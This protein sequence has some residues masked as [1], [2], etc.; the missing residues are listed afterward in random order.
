MTTTTTRKTTTT[1]TSTTRKIS[2]DSV[3]D[4]N[5]TTPNIPDNCTV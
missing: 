2:T 1:T 5:G 4:G 3:N